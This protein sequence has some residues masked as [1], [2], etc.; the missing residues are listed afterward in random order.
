MQIKRLKGEEITPD[1]CRIYTDWMRGESWTKE[2][3][4][5]PTLI[6]RKYDEEFMSCYWKTIMATG[7]GYF[8]ILQHDDKVFGIISGMMG[9]DDIS[10][11]KIAIERY[12]RVAREARGYGKELLK[13]FEDWAKENGAKIVITTC[14]NNQYREK[15][16]RT[17]EKHGYFDYVTNYMKIME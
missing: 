1:L 17:Y 5:N 2:Q 8:S 11:V 4:E 9:F 10:G 13:D 16:K 12:W 14:M 15:M 7:L 6:A 3:K